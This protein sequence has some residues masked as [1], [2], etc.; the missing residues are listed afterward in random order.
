MA[1]PVV[2]LRER[3]A[4]ALPDALG[5]EHAG[6]DPVL[7]R[8]QSDRFGDYQA[9]AAMALGRAL[10][11]SP[12]EVAETIVARL[13]VA[14]ICERVE[15]AGPGFINLSLRD[16][17]IGRELVDSAADAR[18]GVRAE[19]PETVVIDYSHPNVAKEMHV[20]HLR[21]TII[22]DALVRVVGFLGHKVIRQNHLGDWGTPF[23]ML[24]EHLVDVGEQE[25]ARELSV[26]DLNEFYRE[27]HEKFERDRAFADR[28]RRR[29]VALQG[30]DEDTLARWCLLVEESK[31]Y[32]R[33][34]Y[35]RLGVTLTPD[36]DCGESFYNPMLDDVARE[37]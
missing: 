4:A 33:V 28:A 15:V 18:L 34:V 25:A 29:V 9:N 14:D 2:A 13:D 23:G 22:G 31:R 20:G 12:C 10:G 11:R 17:Y 24:I 37:L 19:A 26:G 21:S 32:F 8:S 1:D 5:S 6:A 35:E 3:F 30:G 16:E 27:A 7:R 36:D